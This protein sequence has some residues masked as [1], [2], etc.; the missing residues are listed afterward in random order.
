MAKRIG[1]L[2]KR[3]SRDGK[4]FLSGVLD[5]GPMGDVNIAVFV[6]DKKEK[7][8]HPDYNIVL[9]QKQGGDAPPDEH[10]ELEPF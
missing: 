1:A 2:W 7:D 6:N 9:S 4:K 3:E 8:K 10:T 5:L